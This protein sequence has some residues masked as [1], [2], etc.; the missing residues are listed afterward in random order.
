MLTWLR[1]CSLDQKSSIEMLQN[2][3]ALNTQATLQKA[4]DYATCASP[5]TVG[6]CA[7]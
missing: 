6:F 4:T 1:D 2:T 7:S 3:R 5:V